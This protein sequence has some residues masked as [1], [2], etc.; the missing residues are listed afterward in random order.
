VNPGGALRLVTFNM[1]MGGSRNPDL[2]R[3]L[4]PALE[5]DLLFTQES[6]DPAQFWPSGSWLWSPVPSHHWGTGLWVRD[7]QMTPLPVPDDF[8][9]R[10]VA[11][12]VEGLVWPGGGLS[13]VVALSIHAPTRRGSSYVKEVGRILDFAG[14][15]AGSLPIVLGG[16]FNV[17]VGTRAAGHLPAL[18]RGETALLA[19]LRDDF[20]LVP[21]WQTAHPGERLARTLRWMRRPDSLPYHC[22]GIFI[23]AAWNPALRECTVYEDDDWSAISDHNPVVANLATP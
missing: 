10:V 20:D 5:P 2:W 13:P 9:G 7:G 17:A 22:D 21:C 23:P 12:V 19:R 4:L 15:L 16:D 8:T 18:S 1:G 14:T 3:R 6:R 11:A